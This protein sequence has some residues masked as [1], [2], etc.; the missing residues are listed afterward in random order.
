MARDAW[1]SDTVAWPESVVRW[2]RANRRRA[3]SLARPHGE[4]WLEDGAWVGAGWEIPAA[5]G[6]S[7][8]YT[9]EYLRNRNRLVRSHPFRSWC[10][11]RD[12]LTANHRVPLSKGGPNAI[13]NL[14]V[15]CRSCN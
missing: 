7:A 10:G 14:G 9:E 12:D 4:A 2:P 5:P 11:R 3:F 15:L 13:S 6:S 1:R 8:E